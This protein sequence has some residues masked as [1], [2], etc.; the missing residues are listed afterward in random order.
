MKTENLSKGR[1]G[2]DIT[3]IVLGG[4]WGVKRIVIRNGAVEIRGSNIVKERKKKRKK[5]K[6]MGEGGVYGARWLEAVFVRLLTRCSE[7]VAFTHSSF[8][9]CPPPLDFRTQR[10]WG[11]VAWLHM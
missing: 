8:F 3:K 11:Y 6:E 4:G 2:D 1:R 10:S 5:E 9:P 7:L